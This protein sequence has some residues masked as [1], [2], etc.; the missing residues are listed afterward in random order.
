MRS[1]GSRNHAINL[2]EDKRPPCGAAPLENQDA[3]TSRNRP[4]APRAA[5]QF[6]WTQVQV[7][8]KRLRAGRRRLGAI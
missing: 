2:K 5:A 1:S 7:E 6:S 8:K 4:H 3:L